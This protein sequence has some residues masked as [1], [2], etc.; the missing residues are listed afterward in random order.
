VAHFAHP[1][2]QF[3]CCKLNK[4]DDRQCCMRLLITHHTIFSTCFAPFSQLCRLPAEATCSIFDGCCTS[5][6]RANNSAASFILRL[7]PI[8]ATGAVPLVFWPMMAVGASCT[9]VICIQRQVIRV[10]R[11][12]RDATPACHVIQVYAFPHIRAEQQ[13]HLE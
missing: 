8:T 11:A 3:I 5:C 7:N 2:C 1:N 4:H 13:T 6:W 9:R 12:M 10:Q